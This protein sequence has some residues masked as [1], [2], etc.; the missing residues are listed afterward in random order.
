MI[1]NFNIQPFTNTNNSFLT[2]HN[3]QGLKD[4][5]NTRL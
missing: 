4:T 2:T 5:P 3:V 1:M